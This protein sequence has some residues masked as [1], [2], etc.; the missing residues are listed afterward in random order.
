MHYCYM[1]IQWKCG[2]GRKQVNSGKRISNLGVFRSSVTL[3]RIG[4]ERRLGINEA[5]D[6]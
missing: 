3:L 4:V 6:L 5:G 2:V 1:A